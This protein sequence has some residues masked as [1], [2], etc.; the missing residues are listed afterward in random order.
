MYFA[1]HLHDPVLHWRNDWIYRS[2]LN[3][4]KK[5]ETIDK[6][7]LNF[8]ASRN[9]RWDHRLPFDHI[10]FQ[11]TQKLLLDKILHWQQETTPQSWGGSGRECTGVQ[12]AVVLLISQAGAPWWRHIKTSSCPISMLVKW[13]LQS[14][15]SCQQ[16]VFVVST[17][18]SQSQIDT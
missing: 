5:L 18:K 1:F 4:F 11:E 9:L 14:W 2:M 3:C 12:G 17:T 7:I 8:L 13:R 16:I 15:V 10:W 6:M